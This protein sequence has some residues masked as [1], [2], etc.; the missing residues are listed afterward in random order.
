MD[1]ELLS[2]LGNSLD[3]FYLLSSTA[4]LHGSANFSRLLQAERGAHRKDFL[5]DAEGQ[6]QLGDGVPSGLAL[7]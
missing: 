1:I 3:D 2:P 4:E 7:Q 6:V 5:E